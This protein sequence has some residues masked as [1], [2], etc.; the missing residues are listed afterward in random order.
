MKE[1][2]FLFFFLLISTLNLT[3]AT[4]QSTSETTTERAVRCF[5]Q[6]I[7][8]YWG[9]CWIEESLKEKNLQKW[10]DYLNM[11]KSWDMLFELNKKIMS[12]LKGD[13]S[14]E[15][16]NN[17]W[18]TA[19]SDIDA[20][21]NAKI[22]NNL[23]VIERRN[24][25]IGNLLLILANGFQ[26]NSFN[27]SSSQI[28]GTTFFKDSEY[29]AGFNKICIYKFGATKISRTISSTLTCPISIVE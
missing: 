25:A 8:E 12:N 17:L 11:Q 7:G 28:N 4:P 29:R 18:S 15:S 21:V 9:N 5:Y 20:I 26:P 2:F 16:A 19:V 6:N 27:S 1:K 3:S 13:L 22:Q 23:A 24:K 14:V 10:I